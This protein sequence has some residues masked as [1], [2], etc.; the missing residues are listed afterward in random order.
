MQPQ[1][2][3]A[4]LAGSLAPLGRARMLPGPAYTS[5]AVL[6]Y[7]QRRFFA[8]TW[9]CLGRSDELLAPGETARSATVG[10]VPVLLTRD[11]AGGLRAF[12]NTCR[13]RAHELLAPEGAGRR[14]A[15]V[16][17]YHGWSYRLDGS[18]L[19][20]PGFR[21][22]EGFS[23]EEY[24]LVQLPLETW[25]GWSLV[26]ASADGGPLAEHLGDLD[27]LVTPYAPERLTRLATHAYDVA[28]NW[29]IVVENYHECYHCPLIHPE[30]CRVSPPDSGENYALSGAW[31]GGRMDLRSGTATMSLDGRSAGRPIAGV[32]PRAVL[33]LGLFPNLLLS[34]HPDY[35]MAHRLEPIDVDRTRIECSWYFPS[36]DIDPS[37]AVDFWDLTNRQDWAACESVQRGVASPHYRPGPLGP[38]E[39]AVHAFSGMVARGYLD[40]EAQAAQR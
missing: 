35:V 31:V 30:L 18:L 16:C 12:A 13:H 19:A 7:E 9:T 34:L 37:Y 6:D 3:A 1:F 8:G 15:V 27:G 32:D 14:Q 11:E 33:Y 22:A 39:D 21:D 36:A 17:P 26:N 23:P 4:E 5:R 28:A 2:S 10:G 24:G 20:A 29:K 38:G 40:Q 25:R